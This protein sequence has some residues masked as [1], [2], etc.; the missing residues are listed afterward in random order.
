MEV[1]EKVL[2]SNMLELLDRAPSI[3]NQAKSKE[4]IMKVQKRRYCQECKEETSHDSPTGECLHL[5]GKRSLINQLSSLSRQSLPY[6]PD[7]IIIGM[8]GS[9][10]THL[11]PSQSKWLNLGAVA[12]QEKFT[13]ILKNG[14]ECVVAGNGECFETQNTYTNTILKILSKGRF[15]EGTLIL[16]EFQPNQDSQ[17]IENIFL[18]ALA[19]CKHVEDLKKQFEG[20]IWIVA[21]PLPPV[22][23]FKNQLALYQAYKLYLRINMVLIKVFMQNKLVPLPMMGFME[24]QPKRILNGRVY[25]WTD[26]ALNTPA[27]EEAIRTMH[28]EPTREMFRRLAKMLDLI[29]ESKE[30]MMSQMAILKEDNKKKF[31][32]Y[33][34]NFTYEEYFCFGQSRDEPM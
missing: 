7:G 17:E 3:F 13:T 9:I 26:A 28:G 10:F 2:L 8:E 27:N 33:E 25:E 15:E 4:L 24:K 19:F 21:L 12:K 18:E 29:A 5:K 20:Y 1:F 30:E 6:L 32:Y 31:A 34:K 14:R 11:P 16:L 23:R 22:K